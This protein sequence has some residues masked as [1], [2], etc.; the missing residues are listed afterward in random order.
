MFQ[1]LI[2]PR[3]RYVRRSAPT[4][5]PEVPEQAGPPVAPESARPIEVQELRA[6]VT[7]LTGRFDWLQELLERQ[8][9]APAATTTE[10]RNPPAPST[11]A[12][13]AAEGKGE[14]NA[15]APVVAQ[16]PPAS[17]P[18]R[19]LLHSMRRPRRQ[20]KSAVTQLLQGL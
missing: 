10:S 18:P 2:G 15:A 5:P 7:A 3:R 19:V 1:E 17:I 14:G 16:P 4:Q 11:R 20:S 9:A 12:P 13:N 6:Q 8:V